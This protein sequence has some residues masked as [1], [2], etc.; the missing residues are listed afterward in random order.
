MREDDGLFP[1]ERED[2]DS[3]PVTSPWFWGWTV[4]VSIAVAAHSFPD[5]EF[6]AEFK[7]LAGALILSIAALGSLAI[8]AALAHAFFRVIVR[9]SRRAAL[10][11]D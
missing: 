1:G 4:F 7:F 3:S 5:S 2:D 9:R 10:R 8:A 6:Y 11:A